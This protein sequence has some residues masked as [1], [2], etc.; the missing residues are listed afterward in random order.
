MI[1][2]DCK[3]PI[4]YFEA[5]PGLGDVCD[6]CILLRYQ[7]IPEIQKRLPE[8]KDI[9]KLSY[10]EASDILDSIGMINF[11]IDKSTRDVIIIKDQNEKPS[12]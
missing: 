1:C 2:V 4:P 12:L 6:K 8:G 7:N 11:P 3:Q 9:G 5:Y 10:T